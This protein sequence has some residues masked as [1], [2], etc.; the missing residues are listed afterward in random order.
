MDDT[1][2]AKVTSAISEVS[3]AAEKYIADYELKKFVE[4]FNC[5]TTLH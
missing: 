1:N 4:H 5:L 3:E 2:N